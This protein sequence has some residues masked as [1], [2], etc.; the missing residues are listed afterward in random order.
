MALLT[1]MY[2]D[3]LAAA[4]AGL[5]PAPGRVGVVHGELA[6]D[7]CCEGYLWARTDSVEPSGASGNCGPTTWSVQFSVGV[8]RCASSVNDQ[9]AAPAAAVLEREAEQREADMRALSRA[10]LDV[11]C[12]RDSRAVLLRWLPEG[13]EGGCSGGSWAVRMT[14]PAP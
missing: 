11:G 1:A 2:R 13:P 7:E 12:V 3:V 4:A 10:I 5:S 8:L 14:I 6:W 9:G